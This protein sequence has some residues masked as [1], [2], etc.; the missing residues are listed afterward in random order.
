V[1]FLILVLALCGCRDK[2]ADRVAPPMISIAVAYPGASAEVVETSVVMP[3]ETALGAVKQIRALTARIDTDHAILFAEL[4]PDAAADAVVHDVRHALAGVQRELPQDLLPPTVTIANRDHEPIL[5]LAVR[6]DLPLATLSTH[7]REVVKTELERIPGV[8]QV[9]LSGLAELAVVVRPDL[10]RLGAAGLTM[11]DVLAALQASEAS[12]AAMLEDVIIKTVDGAP[13]K[14]RDVATV[15]QG[16]EREPG[17]TPPALAIRAQAGAK[18]A[19]VLAAVRDAIAKLDLPAGMTLAEIPSPKPARPAPPLVATLT[20]PGLDELRTIAAAYTTR[21]AELGI[22]DIVR[23]PPEGEWEQTV[24]PDRERAAA[25]GIPL[26]DIFA[27]LAAA[28][29]DR[30]GRVVVD[31]A[32]QP[33]V[34]KLGAG[35]LPL[36]KLFVRSTRAGALVPLS[37]IV[38]VEAGQG[39]A[40]ARRNRERM[41][42]LSIYA[43]AADVTRARKAIQERTL[44]AGYRVTF[45]P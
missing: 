21:L 12:S 11:F 16:F 17:A 44:P 32:H 13:I 6:G 36:D 40:I 37:S 7:G 1:R 33:V 42:A 35:Q 38:T 18:N 24:R 19:T 23:E 14:L 9:E 34:I 22:K 5:W 20:G 26:P 8:A 41:I 31:G 29:G 27:T 25:L 43:A 30:V 4:A 10:D 2:A 28:G 45:S 3:I 15:E 39:H